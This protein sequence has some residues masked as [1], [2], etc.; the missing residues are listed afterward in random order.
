MVGG[1][2][3]VMY[4]KVYVGLEL[5]NCQKEILPQT[6]MLGFNHVHRYF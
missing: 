2:Y 3:S 6:Q 5:K 4:Q 1:S